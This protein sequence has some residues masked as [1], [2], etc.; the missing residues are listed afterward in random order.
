MFSIV[1]SIMP[2]LLDEWECQRKAHPATRAL[3]YAKYLQ[4]KPVL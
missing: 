1:V 3:D 2:Q 4:D